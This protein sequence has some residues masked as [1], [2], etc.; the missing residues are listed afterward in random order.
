MLKVE[1]LLRQFPHEPLP[2]L[3]RDALALTGAAF[4]VSA[5]LGEC[6]RSFMLTIPM[7]HEM[8]V[9]RGPFGRAPSLLVLLYCIYEDAGIDV[10]ADAEVQQIS[11][12]SSPHTNTHTHTH[13]HTQL[14]SR[15]QPTGIKHQMCH[16]PVCVLT[17]CEYRRSVVLE[18]SCPRI[19]ALL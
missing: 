7:S 12:L 9:V 3:S 11:E 4:S 1:F 13:T 5:L 19:P 14:Y 17:T 2:D 18:S 16:A 10:A 6:D 8:E 15:A